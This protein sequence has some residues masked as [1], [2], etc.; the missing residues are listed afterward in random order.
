MRWGWLPFLPDLVGGFDLLRGLEEPQHLQQPVRP[1]GLQGRDQALGGVGLEGSHVLVQFRGAGDQVQ[2]VLQNDVAVD[3]E[4]ALALEI[5]PTVEQH[6]DGLRAGEDRQPVVDGHGE[7]VG[8]VVAEEAV[9]GAGHAGLLDREAAA[10]RV[11]GSGASKTWV[12]K[13][14]LRDQSNLTVGWSEG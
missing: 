5:L 8:G 4:L 3:T 12:T 14:E 9:A 6:R 7:E 11:S 2:V 10:S 13:L 1:G